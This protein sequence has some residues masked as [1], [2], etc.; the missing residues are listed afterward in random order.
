MRNSAKYISE[1]TTLIDIASY[2]KHWALNMYLPYIW[3]H[4]MR[5][6]IWSFVQKMSKTTVSR[7]H[8]LSFSWKWVSVCPFF[9]RRILC[10]SFSR[11]LFGMLYT[12]FEVKRFEFVRIKLSIKLKLNIPFLGFYLRLKLF[13]INIS[14]LV[15]HSAIYLQNVVW[16]VDNTYGCTFKL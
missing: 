4:F 9:A 2:D 3:M 8:N 11:L 1:S 13:S 6:S 5:N 16:M 10:V 15:M 7:N 12:G 14:V